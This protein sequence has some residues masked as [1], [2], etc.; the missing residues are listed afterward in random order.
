M[1]SIVL[2]EA[3]QPLEVNR[4]WN[5][6]SAPPWDQTRLRF[7]T[8]PY[9]ILHSRGSS[10]LRHMKLLCG[11]SLCNCG[12]KLTQM[13]DQTKMVYKFPTP[14]LSAKRIFLQNFS[15]F[16]CHSQKQATILHNTRLPISHI[17]IF[18]TICHY[19]KQ[20]QNRQWS[21]CSLICNSTCVC[22]H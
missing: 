18:L 17:F 9:F 8:R 14:A 19:Q 1:Y 5:M 21:R 12:P 15:S 6:S 20:G 16:I 3:S 2:S 10:V 22:H 13:P 11:C 7:T 4:H